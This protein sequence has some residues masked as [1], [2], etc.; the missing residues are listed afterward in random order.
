MHVITKT[1]QQQLLQ[2][3]R[4]LVLGIVAMN[5][6]AALAAGPFA[7]LPSNGNPT[8]SVVDLSNTS[9]VPTTVTV[10]GTANI[11]AF[12]GV[13]FSAKDGML[14]ISDQA[15]ET[16]FKINT[17]TGATVDSYFVGDNPR[18]VAVDQSG[19]HAYVVERGASSLAIVDTSAPRAQAVSKI[20]F[21]NVGGLPMSP[22]GVVL[23]LTG[24]RAYVTDS[25]GEHRLCQVNLV[26]PPSDGQANASDCIAVG[27]DV[28]P[29]PEA[30]AVSPDGARV[31]VVNQTE[32][33]VSVVD[34]TSFTLIRT[35]ALG[36]VNAN[37][38]AIDSSGKRAY[39]GS[40]R[41][42]VVVLD[43]TKVDDM[44]ADPVMGTI[45]DPDPAKIAAVQGVAISSDGTRL[46]A[47]DHDS[48]KLHV[49][50]IVN[51]ANNIIASVPVNTTPTAIGHFTVLDPVY[52]SGFEGGN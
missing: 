33:S 22:S 5:S 28:A 12:Y 52:V 15:N 6:A 9:A 20:N 18:G 2:G 8:F 51:D 29:T 35:I 34:T 44:N 46:L 25:G 14:Y 40:G 43:L 3:A 42:V 49:I 19:K 31:Y 48:N 16:L 21:D 23:N 47:V 38:I 27:S 13:A 36:Y 26:S 32:G 17:T 37:G 24:T 45:N 7:Y 4:L 11:T 30:V 41:G 50:D 39:V 1:R 10:T